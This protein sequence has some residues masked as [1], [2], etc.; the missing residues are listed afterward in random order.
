MK[1]KF[2]RATIQGADSD[3]TSFLAKKIPAVTILGLNNNW[4][5]ILH[6]HNDQAFRINAQNV[7][8]GYRLVLA[9]IVRLDQLPCGA[10]R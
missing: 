3:S 2:S 7:Y 8:L 9:M 1:L 6:S 10:N 5:S 4:P